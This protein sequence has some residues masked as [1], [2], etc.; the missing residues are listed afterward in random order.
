[1]LASISMDPRGRGATQVSATRGR[2]APGPDL[3]K[4][5]ALR[6]PSGAFGRRHLAP[7]ACLREL[8]RAARAALSS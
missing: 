4:I 6:I 7:A 3:A 5:V 1:M 8:R 2:A